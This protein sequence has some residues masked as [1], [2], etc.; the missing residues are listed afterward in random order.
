MGI[1]FQRKTNVC[2]FRGGENRVNIEEEEK[3]NVAK[4]GSQIDLNPK[5]TKSSTNY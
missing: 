4:M 3:K 2:D 1:G 5:H